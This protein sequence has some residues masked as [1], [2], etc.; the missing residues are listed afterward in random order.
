[1]LA[2]PVT[3]LLLMPK[4]FLAALPASTGEQESSP[5][6]RTGISVAH[7][8]CAAFI[9]AAVL[10]TRSGVGFAAPDPAPAGG[11]TIDFTRQIRPI[12]S[13]NC[14]ACH[15]N[16]EKKRKAGLRL[17]LKSEAFKKLKSG[18][19]AL[20]PGDL[21][22]SEAAR[23]IST[24]DPDDQMPPPKSGKHLTSEQIELIRQWIL[25]GAVYRDHWA[26]TKPVRPDLPEVHLKNWPRN[27]ID[28]FVLVRLEREGMRPSPEASREALIRRASL[29]LT[30]LPPSVTEVEQFVRDNRPDA[31]ERL[32]DRLLASPHY[33]ERWARPWLDEAR[34]ADSNG[35]EADFKRTIWPYRDWVIGALNRDMPFDQFTI[36][37][38]AG[39]L[40]PKNTREQ[41][42]ATGFHRNTMVN[43]EGG[44]DEEEFRVAAIVDRVN[45]T[46]GVWMGTTIGCAQCHNHKYDPFT[47][48][49]YYQLFAFLNETKDKGR[50]NEPE[51][52]LPTPEQ[53]AKR[54][55]IHAK[56]KPLEKTLNTQTPELDEA[57]EMWQHELQ[58]ADH[59]IASSWIPLKPDDWDASGDVILSPLPDG[60]LRSSGALPDTSTYEIVTSTRAPVITAIRLEALVDPGLP[61]GSCGRSDEGDFVLTEFVVEAS[62]VEIGNEDAD[63]DDEAPGAPI[64]F[65]SAYADFSMENYGVKEAIDGKPKTGWSIAAFEPSNRVDHVAVFV[66]KQAIDFEGGTRLRFWLRQNSDRSQHLLGRFRLSVSTAPIEAHRMWGKVPSETRA[67]LETSSEELNEAQENELAKYYRSVD[68]KLDR[69][70]DQVA[71]LKKQEPKDVATTLVME[72]VSDPRPT[73]LLIR[74]SFLTKGDEVP[75][76]TPAV[77]HPWPSGQPTNRLGFAHWLVDT[78]N[79]LI[80]RVTMNR[81]WAQY[82]GR[83]LVETSEEFGAQGELPTHPELLDWLATEFF[84]RGWS[85]KAMHRLIATSAAYRQDSAVTPELVERDPFNRLLARG[86]RFR[87]EAEMLRDTALAIGGLLN[88]KTGGPSVFPYQPD[89]VWNSPYNGD[90][91]AI[92]KEGDQFRR[93]I[94]TFWRRTAPYAAFAAFDAPSREVMCERRARSNTPIQALVTLNDPAFVAA[95]NGLAERILAEGG[96]TTQER[97]AFAFE[98]CVARPPE[99]GELRPLMRL[100]EQSVARFR[101]HPDS[102]KALAGVGL[103]KAPDASNLPERAAW[104]VIANVLLNLDETLNKS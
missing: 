15:G 6:P 31:Y 40:L 21:T 56:L 75:P 74:G 101:D 102:A 28:Y 29:D 19:Y 89:G 97:I 58:T 34:Y 13:E 71:E 65:D 44:T 69:I 14:F 59:D 36:E 90:K 7:H 66:P 2:C 50:S 100:Y 62:P 4:Q 43:T 32:I 79:P 51:M 68:P 11:T 88:E 95:A 17:D 96:H 81:I 103:P 104:T 85:L 72:V 18:D 70:R 82:F 46:F 86:P 99:A 1:M 91:W 38:L 92:S 84:E 73:H 54:D 41:K 78:N 33:G 9:G 20:V 42:I 47:Q 94:Y 87:M 93:G 53:Q 12:L 45:T 64:T 77:L 61:H 52:D 76:G 55:E 63:R 48:R 24:T 26:Y 39:D 25:Q 8:L 57:Q 30:G 98:A 80:G 10:L 83:G 35:Y 5:H 22:R 3:F 27:P 67:L 37:Q 23:R 16:D 60:S 49:E